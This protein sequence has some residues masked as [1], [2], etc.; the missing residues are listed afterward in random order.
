MKNDERSKTLTSDQAIR[1]QK[2]SLYIW[3]ALN[4]WKETSAKFAI[5]SDVAFRII[6]YFN[7]TFNSHKPVIFVILKPDF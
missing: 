2:L 3:T 6:L 1:S 4:D 5:Y 7:Y